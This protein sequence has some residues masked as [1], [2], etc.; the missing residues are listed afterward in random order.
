MA[1]SADAEAVETSQATFTFQPDEGDP[2]VLP[3]ADVL[4]ETVDGK[5]ATEFLWE[6]RKMNETYQ[7]FEFMDRAKVAEDVQRRIVRLSTEERRKLFR[8]WFDDL[9]KP[10]VEG[11]LP[12]E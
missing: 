7:S 9:N 3:R 2:I 11:E 12:P 6:I 4:W 8:G 10:P 1:K 5:G